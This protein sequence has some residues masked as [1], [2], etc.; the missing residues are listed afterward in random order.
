MNTQLTALK[1]A[2]AY[3]EGIHPGNMTPMA[4]EY[5]NKAITAL[6]TAIH[7][8]E[9][10]EQAAVAEPHKKQEPVAFICQ[11]N[12]YMAGD[13]DEFCTATHIPLY[14]TPPVA[15]V[16]EPLEYWN[17]VE[18]W[19]KIDEVRQHFDSVGCGTIYKNA[20]EDRVP[21]YTAA[22]RQWV[23]LTQQDIDIA[24]DDTQEGGGFDEFARAIEQRL[25]EKNT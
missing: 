18:G 4:E 10:R 2:L 21:L 11:G 20:G 6:R 17:A 3:L 15:P 25:K 13:V 14:T 7:A 22:Q 1:L 9:L 5:W 16:R 12:A 8:T 24:F 23:G 19:V